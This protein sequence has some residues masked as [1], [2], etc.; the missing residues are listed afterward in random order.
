[1]TSLRQRREPVETGRASL[2]YLARNNDSEVDLAAEGKQFLKYKEKN[3]TGKM[4]HAKILSAILLKRTL[5]NVYCIYV[6]T[7]NNCMLSR[8][9]AP[10]IESKKNI[11]EFKN[12]HCFQPD[13]NFHLHQE[14]QLQSLV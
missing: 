8:E 7:V 3:F 2:D 1:M 9:T 13:P 4:I 11:Q 5:I 10:K 12:S 14:I 6:C